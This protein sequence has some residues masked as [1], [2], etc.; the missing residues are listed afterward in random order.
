MIVRGQFDKF[1]RPG[2]RKV[3]IDDYQEMLSTYNQIFNVDTSGKAFEDDLVSTGLGIAVSKPE[4]E[5]IAFDRPKFRGRVR[6]IHAGYGLGYE[7][8]QESVED[9]Q[10][11]ALTSQG[12]TNLA[13]SMRAAEETSAAAVLNGAFTSITAYDSTSV[14]L[15]SASHVTSHGTANA[16]APSSG[17]DLS[18][19]ALKA[20]MERYMGLMTDR[21]LKITM[22]PKFLLVS[23]LN[24]FN[25]QEIL[26][27]QYVTGASSGGE[28]GS[29]VSAYGN[30]V[31]T[32]MGL[33]PVKWNYLTDSDAWF[34]LAPKG[35]HKLNFFW[36]R[37]PDFV[38]GTD[39]RVGIAWFGV[40]GRWVAGA[41]DYRG[42]DGS[43]GAA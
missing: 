36:R 20:S 42:I 38:S 8:T 5:P 2:A 37:K 31:V 30:N 19:A 26:N 21:D 33:V 23:H 13:R 25:A 32:Q 29:I 12:S 43:A 4:G 6:Y 9:D 11:K 24:W 27:T 22:M 10:Y 1:L 40:T 28:I 41:T 17:T 3:Y 35:Q 7:I 15:C 18:V 16:N 39:E 14:Y 34:T